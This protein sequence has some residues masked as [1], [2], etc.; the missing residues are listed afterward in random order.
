M[1]FLQLSKEK[2]EFIFY[3]LTG[4]LISFIL[5]ILPI[6]NPDLGWHI[7][8]ARW[9][10]ENKS[11]PYHEFLSWTKEGEI[12]INPETFSHLIFY[13]FYY[14]GGE[15]GLFLLKIINLI[16]MGFS[17]SFLF[18]VFSKSYFNLIWVIP[19]FFIAILNLS[20]LRPDNYTFIL[21]TF[22]LS[23]LHIRKDKEEID[24][25]DILYIFTIFILWVNLHGGYIYGLILIAIFF[26]GSVL[27]ENLLFIYGENKNISFKK[28]KKY[29]LFLIPAL[30]GSLINPYSYKI[31]SVFFEHYINLSKFQKY[32]VE[33]QEFEIKQPNLLFFIIFMT[34]SCISYLIYFIKYRKVNFIEIFLLFFF[35][36]NSLLHIRLASYAYVTGLYIL[37]QVFR[38]KINI[39]KY[40]ISFLLPVI[41][42]LSYISY[43]LIP[44]NTISLINN[45]FYI[46]YNGTKSMINFIKNN[47]AYLKDLKMYNGWN[48]GGYL[49]WHLYGYKKTFMAG[50]YIFSDMLVEYINIYNSKEDFEKFMI[51]YDIEMIVLPVSQQFT[52][53]TYKIKDHTYKVLRPIYNIPID[54]NRWA[55]VYFDTRTMILIKREKANSKF[56][57]DNEYIF[58][59]PYDFDKLYIDVMTDKKIISRI[60]KEIIRY[61]SK[62]KESQDPDETFIFSL[63]TL[64]RDMIYIEKGVFNFEK[65]LL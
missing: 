2:R 27:N 10:I 51:K 21:F 37:L 18:S 30:I 43:N 24:F 34:A 53:F 29:L 15:K 64:F 5:L 14:T 25:K 6:T 28:S 16:L 7:S 1:L 3:F 13:F 57:K 39:L 19:S 56:L 59:K 49:E 61:I 11:I 48:I 52:P 23:F 46:P 55:L 32:I 9:L 60:K 12:F 65:E 62:N 38:D 45:R 58:L 42:F 17:V 41:I 63:T 4:I 35:T 40:K 20:D 31:Y 36:I 33:W 47:Y 22:L 8:T 54:F 26:T 50:R 44:F